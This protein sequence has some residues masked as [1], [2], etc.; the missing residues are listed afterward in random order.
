M[1]KGHFRSDSDYCA[2]TEDNQRKKHK[3]GKR[4]KRATEPP[5]SKDEASREHNEEIHDA[6][7]LDEEE[8]HPKAPKEPKRPKKRKQQDVES[9]E[10]TLDPEEETQ[11]KKHDAIF[12]KYQ[13]AA[14]QAEAERANAPPTAEDDLMDVDSPD[15]AA[16]P[17]LHGRHSY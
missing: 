10:Q 3:K 8:T 12:A 6:E 9:E 7:K 2:D 13:K 16:A 5:V 4:E 1:Q 14:E 11:R 15:A 17:E